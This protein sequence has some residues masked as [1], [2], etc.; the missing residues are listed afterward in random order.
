MLRVPQHPTRRL[1]IP[2]GTMAGNA[3]GVAATDSVCGTLGVAG[4]ED[5][6]EVIVAHDL[7]D[8]IDDMGAALD[9]SIPDSDK[10]LERS[11]RR[12]L[13]GF[14]DIGDDSLAVGR[15]DVTREEFNVSISIEK[16][17][18]RVN[19]P[20]DPEKMPLRLGMRLHEDGQ[21][22]T[23]GRTSDKVETTAVE[24]GHDG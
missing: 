4:D 9:T 18:R 8:D 5:D 21:C 20:S 15:L 2:D 13:E 24:G 6:L 1:R 7:L 11:G 3:P 23:D 16:E 14:L 12:V 22:D 10:L 19:V 17:R